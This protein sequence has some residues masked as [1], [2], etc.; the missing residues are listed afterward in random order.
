MGPRLPIYCQQLITEP[1]RA[2]LFDW[3]YSF[4]HRQNIHSTFESKMLNLEV[5]LDACCFSHVC[6]LFVSSFEKVVHPCVPISTFD[7]WRVLYTSI[8][9]VCFSSWASLRV[10]LSRMCL[11]WM[12]TAP[13]CFRRS[14]LW[15]WFFRW[16]CKILA[17]E[18]FAWSTPFVGGCREDGVCGQRSLIDKCHSSVCRPFG[19]P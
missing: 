10:L 2:Q 19:R 13:W 17:C 15:T 9:V 8:Y 3:F 6:F 18:S 12:H 11:G 4:L 1:L 16:V 7:C 5:H 14:Q